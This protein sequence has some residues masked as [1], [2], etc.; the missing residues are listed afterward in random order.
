MSESK[1]NPKMPHCG[2][3]PLVSGIVSP[4][5]PLLLY[6]RRRDG[7]LQLN[8]SPGF[9]WVGVSALTIGAASRRRSSCARG[10]QGIDDTRRWRF[11]RAAVSR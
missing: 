6:S 9:V 3:K 10:Q 7:R 11:L 1:D 5:R 8:P 2:G 4:D